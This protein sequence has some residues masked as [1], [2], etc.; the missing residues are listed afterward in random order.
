[1]D[2]TSTISE[3][4]KDV[5]PNFTVNPPGFSFYPPSFENLPRHMLSFENRSS[6]YPLYQGFHFQPRVPQMGFQT[7]HQNSNKIFVG[8]PVFQA[9]REP[10]PSSSQRGCPERLFLFDK[11][12]NG[13]KKESQPELVE[14][15]L[16]LRLGLVSNN[17][18][19]L[20]SVDDVD[21]DPRSSQTGLRSKE[22]SF[23]P[24][25]SD[26][27]EVDKMLTDVR[28]RKTVGES[29]HFLHLHPDFEQMKRRGL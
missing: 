22:F 4:T 28:K 20:T 25:N 29:Q 27:K 24:L 5:R 12:D 8:T 3:A 21:L 26:A 10:L 9:A 11:E 14:C 19:E 13:S 15:D 23:F 2:Q 7:A 17:G 1:M 16:S 6:V 18:K